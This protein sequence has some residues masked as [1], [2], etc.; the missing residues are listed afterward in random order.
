MDTETIVT[1]SVET[2]P[3][4]NI[5]I[6]GHVDHGKSTIIGRL[7][8]DTDSLPEGKLEQVKANC[9]RNS[10]PFEYAFLL[11]ALKDE[12]SQGITIDAARV[13]F[14]TQKRDYIIIDAPGHIEFLKNMVTG[15]S[16]AES[17]FLVI[18]ANEGIQENSRRHGYMLSMLGISQVCVLINKMDLVDNSRQVFRK[19]LKKYTKFLKDIGIENAVYIPVSGREGCNIAS[20]ST[21]MPWYESN[22]VVEQLDLFTKKKE[23]ADLPFRMPVQDVYKFT[24]Y[25]DDRRIIAGTIETGS[26]SIGDE[27]VFYPSGKKS[28]VRSLEGFNCEPGTEVASP[29]ALGFTMDKQIYVTRGELA[30]KSKEIKP[31]VASRL[32]VNLFWLGREPMRPDHDYLFKIGTTRVMARLSDVLRVIDASDLS[33]TAMKES[34]SQHDVAECIL[35]LG[36]ACAFDVVDDIPQT[37]RFVIVDDYEIRG[38]GII[39]EAIADEQSLARDSV[40]SRNLN[41]NTGNISALERMERYGQKPAL[42]VFT[43]ADGSDKQRLA[44]RLEETLFR[45]GRFVYFLGLGNVLHGVNADIDGTKGERKEHIRRLGELANIFLD[46]GIILVATAVDLTEEEHQLIRLSVDPALI[47]TIWVGKDKT[48]DITADFQIVN[49]ENLERPL[50]DIMDMLRANQIITKQ[51]E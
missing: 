22:T 27:V 42:I 24:N 29:S 43:G 10:K 7:L 40:F 18:D 16:R 36:R 46:A 6:V 25:E 39:R 1:T 14:G 30:V 44:R 3:Q 45:E 8:S 38:G 4:M 33:S 9:E 17:A 49:T 28:R 31:K 48:T 47:E 21:T 37:S 2:K 32:R 11:D 12:Q 41:W 51:G 26:L 50:K 34:I 5:V 20:L 35:K 13:F 15:A 19:I 23:K